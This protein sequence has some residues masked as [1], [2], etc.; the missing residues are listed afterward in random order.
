MVLLF[1][2]KNVLPVI[3]IMNHSSSLHLLGASKS[4]QIIELPRIIQRP[5]KIPSKSHQNPIKIPSNPVKS[6]QNPIKSDQNPKKTVK[7]SHHITQHPPNIS[8]KISTKSPES[9]APNT[10]RFPSKLPLRRIRWPKRCH[11]SAAGDQQ[12]HEPILAVVLG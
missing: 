4:H 6:S 12:G 5:P 9:M 2:K 8:T 11:R 7:I 10:D 3:S 1:H